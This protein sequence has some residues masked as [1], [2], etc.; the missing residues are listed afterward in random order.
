MDR[1]RPGSEP[2]ARADDLDVG[3]EKVRAL[4]RKRPVV[5]EPG[6]TLREAAGRMEEQGVSSILVDVG[7][8][9]LGI[10]TDRDLRSRVVAAGLSLET[11]VGEVMSAPVVTIGAEQTGDELMLLMIDQGIRHVPV[12]SSRGE[13]LGVATDID[14]LANET[15]TPIML[16]RAIADAG[17]VDALRPTVEQLNATLIAMHAA[18]L[19]ASRISGILSVI[20]DALVRRVIELT[21]AGLGPPPAELGWLSLGSFGRRE[22]VPSSDLDSGMV[23]ADS[24]GADVGGYMHRLGREVVD[25]LAAMGWQPDAHGVSATGAMSASSMNDWRTAIANWLDGPTSEPVLVAI[26]IVLDARTIYGPEDGLDVRALLREARP[27]PELLRLLLRQA[28][29]SKPPT[30]FMRDIVVEHS[31]EHAG[32]FDIKHGG[33][34]PIV[35]VARYAALAAG[36]TTTSTTERLRA[37]AEVGILAET[38]AATLEE[39]FELFAE[40]RLEH[41]IRQLEAGSSPDDLIDPKTLNPLMRRYLRDAFRAVASVQRSLNT[42]LA[43]ST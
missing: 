6:V 28:L 27:R 32:R 19:E 2:T 41:Q 8:G 38:D 26:S 13:L 33:L 11:P 25:E 22:A 20:V 1:P 15:H 43:W 9:E 36:A 3:Q 10:V 17:Q 21:V 5:C 30:G 7:D 12:V 39:A 14:L 34:L 24:S 31:G 18:G 42:K 23:W 16:R 29:A 4:V 40:L 37:A 35:N